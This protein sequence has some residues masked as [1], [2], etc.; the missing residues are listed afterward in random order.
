MVDLSNEDAWTL[1]AR[2][3]RAVSGAPSFLNRIP[4]ILMVIPFISEYF[5]IFVDSPN[6]RSSWNW[7]GRL[8]LYIGGIE[9]FSP[10]YY[11]ST[12]IILNEWRIVYFP[13]IL[14]AQ[15]SHLLFEP[16]YWMPDINIELYQY[17][18]G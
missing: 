10:A 13:G 12:G 5:K 4:S 1:I 9:N 11:S 16:P 7:A 3:S 8:Y 14:F 2:E 17:Q 6:G 15:Q 18:E